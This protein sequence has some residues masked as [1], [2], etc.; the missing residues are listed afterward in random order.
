MEIREKR[1]AIRRSKIDHTLIQ[2]GTAQLSS[3]V[4]ILESWLAELEKDDFANQ[5][6]I[7]ARV[8]Y[9]DMLR[10]RKEMLEALLSLEKP[11]P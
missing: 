1:K 8:A 4:E 10:S 5:V 6:V 9:N 7:D 2:E 11:I 3:E